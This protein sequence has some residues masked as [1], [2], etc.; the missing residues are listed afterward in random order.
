MDAVIENYEFFEYKP[1]T[2]VNINDAGNDIPIIV[3]NEEI[4]TQPSNS[5]LVLTGKMTATKTTSGAT[6][7]V[8]AFDLTHVKTVNN[9]FLNLFDRIDYYIGDNKIDTIRKPGIATTMKGLVSFENDLLFC[10]AGWKISSDGDETIMSGSGKFQVFIP[11]RIVMGFSR[12]TTNF[13]IG[14]LKN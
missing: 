1:P 9:G 2:S 8:N 4:I 10:D 3:Y 6:T 11:M 5:L 12:V 7:A 13:S 14:C